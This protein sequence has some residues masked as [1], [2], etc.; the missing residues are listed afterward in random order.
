MTTMAGHRVAAYHTSRSRRREGLVSTRL[1]T[2][3]RPALT[4]ANT[5]SGMT[6]VATSTI[7]WASEMPN[8]SRLTSALGITR[9]T[10]VCAIKRLSD[11][12]RASVSDEISQIWPASGVGHAHERDVGVRI[13]DGQRANAFAVDRQAV[14]DRAF[15]CVA[16]ARDR[17]AEIAVHQ[18]LE[19]PGELRGVSTLALVDLQVPGGQHVVLALHR[20][21]ERCDGASRR[22]AVERID[23]LRWD[24]RRRL[25]Q[26][27]RDLGAERVSEEKCQYSGERHD[28]LG[29]ILGLRTDRQ[30]QVGCE[31]REMN[32]GLKERS[33]ARDNGEHPHDARQRQQYDVSWVEAEV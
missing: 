7:Q 18:R 11:G 3:A 29:D 16:D 13:V 26:D 5:M 25:A 2:N 8:S 23:G 32:T 20:P 31:H 10:H 4:S 24:R 30:E 19:I 27:S 14:V 1:T 12:T 9:S 21:D 6:S 22:R 28:R 33:S 17:L 15:R